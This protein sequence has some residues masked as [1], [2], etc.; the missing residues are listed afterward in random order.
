MEVLPPPIK[1]FG[2]EVKELES[3]PT[4]LAYVGY[5]AGDDD[6]DIDALIAESIA[7]DFNFSAQGNPLE[8]FGQ[9]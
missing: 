5:N 1:M 9:K 2:P 8:L 7:D 3:L 6:N 4:P